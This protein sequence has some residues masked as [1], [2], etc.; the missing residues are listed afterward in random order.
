MQ[1]NRN[2]V[3]VKKMRYEKRYI[4]ISVFANHIIL[5]LP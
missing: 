1:K 5:L 2:F 3:D 4:H